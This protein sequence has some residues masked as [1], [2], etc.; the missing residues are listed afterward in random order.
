MQVGV[1]KYAH[2]ARINFAAKTAYIGDVLLGSVFYALV[3]YIFV[4][5]W[6]VLGLSPG[7]MP[8]GL[9]LRELVW[10]LAASEAIMLGRA[11]IAS[12]VSDEVKSGAIAY[13]LGR[14]YNYLGFKLSSY[15]GD[16]ALRMTVNVV[17]GTTVALAAVGPI[18]VGPGRLVLWGITAALALTLNFL[19]VVCIS[20][21]AFWVEDTGPFFWIYSK[22]LFVLGGLFAPIDLYPQFLRRVAAASP[23]NLVLYAPAKLLVAFD[24]ATFAR[25]VMMQAVWLL[26]L[27]RLAAGLYGMGV[28]RLNVNGG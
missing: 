7:F 13:S 12:E 21:S 20:L 1:G 5:L 22:L 19:I 24:A 8:D 25:T 18:Q 4:Q 16:T 2:I 15:W 3:L 17:I 26:V 10:Y 11:P 28:R 9:G 27:G 14:P 6:Q 23:F